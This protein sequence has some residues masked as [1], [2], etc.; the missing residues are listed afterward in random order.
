[1]TLMEDDGGFIKRLFLK[2]AALNVTAQ[3]VSV[4]GPL[5]GNIT[6][7]RVFGSEGL[8][9]AG[10]CSPLFFLASFAGIVV[11][12]GSSTIAAKLLAKDDKEG[13]DR[14]YT[15]SVIVVVI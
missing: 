14:V 3:L 2:H 10:L 6:V 5:I 15:T 4:I 11:S 12:G 9:I 8:A 13:V 1:M 7:G